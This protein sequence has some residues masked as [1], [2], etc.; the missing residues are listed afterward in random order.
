MLSL[1]SPKGTRDRNFLANYAYINLV[2]ELAR[3]PA[4]AMCW[5]RRPLCDADLGEA[6]PAGEAAV[7]VPEI[8]R[9]GA[10]TE[11]RES[12]R[13]DWKRA[14]TAGPGIHLHG[15]RPGAA[16]H[17]GG[18]RADRDPAN[19]DGSVL[20]VNDVASVELGP[21]RTTSGPREWRSRRR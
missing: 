13:A 19:R 16:D 12:G 14:G 8:V 4:W 20:R 18:V 11:H 2:D 15:A 9:A 1:Y 21:R 17:A 6:G 3:A 7:T 10:T 5:F